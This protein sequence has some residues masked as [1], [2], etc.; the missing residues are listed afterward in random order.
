MDIPLGAVAEK[1]AS[2]TGDAPTLTYDKTEWA[3]VYDLQHRIAYFGTYG[4]LT[5]RKVDLNKVDF[6][7]KTIQHLPMPTTFQALDV[8]PGANL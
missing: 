7:G 3:T 8:T 1:T 4:D 2:K 5:I 6:G